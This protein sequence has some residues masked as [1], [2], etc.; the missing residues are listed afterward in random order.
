MYRLKN[1]AFPLP[2]SITRGQKHVKAGLKPFWEVQETSERHTIYVN[3]IHILS[4]GCLD[5]TTISTIYVSDVLLQLLPTQTA[6]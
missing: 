5:D 4:T 6:Q 3:N 2:C 1:D